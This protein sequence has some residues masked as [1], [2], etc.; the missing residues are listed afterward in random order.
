MK[1]V[2]IMPSQSRWLTHVKKRGPIHLVAFINMML[3]TLLALK[4]ETFSLMPLV[5]GS[6]NVIIMYGTYWIF[7]Y[8]KMGDPYIA[9]I[10]SMLVTIGLV[11][12]Y[13]LSPTTG[14]RFFV[15]FLIG[16][17][18][19]VMISVGY[20]LVHKLERRFWVF[21]LSIIGLMVATQLF[22]VTI[23]GAKNWIRVGTFTIQPSELIKVL[24]AMA[25]ASFFADPEQ[26]IP[27]RFREH[28][29][30]RFYRFGLMFLV[31]VVMGLFLLQRE[32]GSALMLF[33]VY[34]SMMY[35]FNRHLLFVAG[36]LLIASGLGY[37][38]MLM[39]THVQVRITAWLDPFSDIANR[40]FQITQALFAIGSGGFFG[41][42]LAL[43]FP[44]FIPNVSTD[45]IFAAICEEMGIF[46][47]IAVLL[48]FFLLVYRGIKISM[49]L[50]DPF[51]K[52][53]AFGLAVTIGY[54][55]F[56]IIGGIIRVVPLTGITLPFISY[57]GSSL[58]VSYMTLG[59]LQALSGPIL[60]Q[61][62]LA[63]EAIHHS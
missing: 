23:N 48:L 43:G 30:A 9:S 7:K 54:Q 55:T 28:P 18:L 63:S 20:P 3:F 33:L 17:V 13:R 47:G 24:F 39:F 35:V 40:G 29:W 50:Y 61:E 46:G 19:Y 11:M 56:V 21:Y 6:A 2:S 25:M 31:Y 49:R 16:N 51:T 45:L 14:M 37:V 38:A 34:I 15:W 44:H 36:N 32:L 60:K 10:V 5:L 41:T 52:A 59:V 27:K 62:V 57:G 4:G 1:V 8:N 12:Q 58:V 22:G 26:L 42:G 53:L